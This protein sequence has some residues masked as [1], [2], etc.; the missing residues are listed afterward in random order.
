MHRIQEEWLKIKALAD[1]GVGEWGIFAIV[2]LVGL[3]SFALGRLSA[4]QEGRAVVSVHEASQLASPRG[5][6]MGGLVVASRS[7][8]SYYFPWCGGGEKINEGNKVW[9]KTEQEAKA[10]G[11]APAKNCKGLQ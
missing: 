10:A 3:S 8:S 11:Y 1:Q 6:Y 5:V 2:V 4:L 7:G 9:F